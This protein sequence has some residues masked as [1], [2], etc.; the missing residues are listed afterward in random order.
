MIN[1]VA[2]D[3]LYKI[4]ESIVRLMQMMAARMFP[5]EAEAIRRWESGWIHGGRTIST[6]PPPLT[7]TTK[8]KKTKNNAVSFD[9]ATSCARERMS[10]ELGIMHVGETALK[11]TSP[12]GKADGLRQQRSR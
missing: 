8:K 3:W 5:M 12:V 2:G 1:R 11:R 6:R 7:Q 4:A 9:A 10:G